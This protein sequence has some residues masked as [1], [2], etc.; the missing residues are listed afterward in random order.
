MSN[1]SQN[2]DSQITQDGYV[3]LKKGY[4]PSE[5]SVTGGHKPEKAELKPKNP[6]KKK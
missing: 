3:P 1:K 5:G 2:N 6:P 4:Q